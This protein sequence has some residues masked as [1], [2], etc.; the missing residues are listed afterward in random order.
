MTTITIAEAK[1]LANAKNLG[2]IKNGWIDLRYGALLDP[3]R[4]PGAQ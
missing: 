3:V 2:E 1:T 4:L